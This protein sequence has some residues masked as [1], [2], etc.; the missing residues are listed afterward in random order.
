MPDFMKA[1][2]EIGLISNSWNVNGVAEVIAQSIEAGFW[3]FYPDMKT[4]D[5]VLEV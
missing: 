3:F 4:I 2:E 1:Q 5:Q